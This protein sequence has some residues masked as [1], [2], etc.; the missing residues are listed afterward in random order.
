MYNKLYNALR[1]LV[2]VILKTNFIFIEPS[3]KSK[4]HKMSAQHKKKQQSH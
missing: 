3:E 1:F 2:V 4:Q